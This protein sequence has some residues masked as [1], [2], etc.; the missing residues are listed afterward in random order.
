MSDSDSD[1]FG[2]ITRKGRMY[3]KRNLEKEN[4]SSMIKYYADPQKRE[5]LKE[6]IKNYNDTIDTLKAKVVK[7]NEYLAAYEPHNQTQQN[8]D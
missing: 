5:K 2:V 1:S 3:R 4:K 6:R 7:L 8:S